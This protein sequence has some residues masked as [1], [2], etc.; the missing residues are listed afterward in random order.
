MGRFT[1]IIIFSIFILLLVYILP[2]SPEFPKPP[3]DSVQSDQPADVE[4][5]LRR[6][7]YTN[8]SRSEV[9]SHYEKEFNKG[10]K[11]YTPRLNYPPEDAQLLIRDQTKSTFLEE[12]VHPLRESLYVNGFEPKSEEYAQFF[13]GVRWNQRIIIRYVPSSVWVR[14]LILVLTMVF[15]YFLLKEYQYAKKC[16]KNIC[17]N[18]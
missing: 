4:S 14:V 7:Y 8:L 3:I 2:K 15:S 13:R 11:I 10:F 1:K 5:P 16:S 9:I 18:C 17:K 12:I 6:A